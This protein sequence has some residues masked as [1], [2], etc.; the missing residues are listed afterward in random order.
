MRPGNLQELSGA[1][2]QLVETAEAEALGDGDTLVGL[3]TQLSRLQAVVA[4]AASQFDSSGEW[5]LDGARAAPVWMAVKTRLPRSEC[6]RHLRLGR[7]LRVMPAIRAA[8]GRGDIGQAQVAVLARLYGPRTA[9]A[10]ARDEELLVS[11]AASLRYD[12]FCRAAEYWLAHADPD[13]SDD[14]EQDRRN[15][16]DAY[17]AASVGGMYLGRMTLDPVS[18]AIVAGEHARIESELFEADWAEA[19]ARLGRDPLAGELARSAAQRRADAFVRMAVRSASVP[20]G[21]RPPRPLFSVLVGYE[22]LRGRIC[23]LASGQVVSP[24]GLLPWLTEAEVERVVFRPGARIEVSERA[25]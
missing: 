9:E 11:Q 20:T 23:E 1:I 15:R 10:L 18:G 16:R 25:R 17:L 12:Q 2:D 4:R 24:A 5:S 19:K 21:A 6:A 3:M 8:F 13:G 22:T 7:F 14:D